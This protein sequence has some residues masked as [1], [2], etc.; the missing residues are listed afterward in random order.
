MQQL[1]A[2][3]AASARKNPGYKNLVVIGIRRRGAVLAQRLHDLI[4]KE[5]GQTIPFGSLDISFYRDDFSNVGANPIVAGTDI[6]FDLEGKKILLVDDVLFTGR[7]IRAALDALIDFGRPALVRLMVMVDRGH[8]ELPIQ[9]DFSGTTVKATRKQMVEVRVAELDGK[10]GI[11]LCD[12][13]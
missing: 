4:Q 11:F 2:R 10:D 13:P 8:R 12:K 6:L 5:S 7:T 9:A 3:L 1:L